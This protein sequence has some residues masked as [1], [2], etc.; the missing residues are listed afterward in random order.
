MSEDALKEETVQ[1]TL[2]TR[3]F[4]EPSEAD[5]AMAMAIINNAGESGADDRQLRPLFPHLNIHQYLGV[6]EECQRRGDMRYKPMMNN[7]GKVG[8]QAYMKV[9]E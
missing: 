7:K 2:P 9:G 3:K 8:Y 5:V 4:E 6:L 1:A